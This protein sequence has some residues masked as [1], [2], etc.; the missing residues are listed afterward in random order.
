[1]STVS[2]PERSL[3]LAKL[4]IWCFWIV[5]VG[6]VVVGSIPGNVLLPTARQRNQL[7]LVMPEGWAFFTRDAQEE[8]LYV[9]RLEGDRLIGIDERAHRALPLAAVNRMGRFRHAALAAVAEPVPDDQWTECRRD[10]AACAAAR[11]DAPLPVA[12]AAA[13]LDVCGPLVLAKRR[14]APWVWFKRNPR[15]EMPSRIAK[16]V[17]PC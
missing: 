12:R 2:R 8:D 15:F 10:V 1:M 9:Y 4:A 17:V 6:A 14:P 7:R 3:Q 11:T 13:Q 5:V 16:V